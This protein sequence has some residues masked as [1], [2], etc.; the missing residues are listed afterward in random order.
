MINLKQSEN[1]RRT[2]KSIK[3]LAVTSSFLLLAIPLFVSAQIENPLKFNSIP[4]F[5][6]NLL[7]YIVRVGGVIATLGFIWAGFLYVRARGN[8]T[9]LETAKKALLNTI[10]GTALLLGAQIIG[11]IIKGTIESVTR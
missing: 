3:L 11:T 2:S 6:S 1:S 8:E 5:I 9:E 4:L 7:S 10:Y